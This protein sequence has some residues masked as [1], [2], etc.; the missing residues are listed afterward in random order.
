MNPLSDLLQ[1]LNSYKVLDA[2]C[3]DGVHAV[4]LKQNG[5]LDDFKQYYG[6]DISEKVIEIAKG[7]LTTNGVRFQTG[8]V[9][10]I[11]FEN[12]FFDASFSFGV[13]AY[14][15]NPLLSLQELTRVTKKGGMVGIWVYPRR[16]GLGGFVFSTVRK[17]CS[18]LGRRF[19]SGL[20]HTIV[21]FL[22]FLPTRSVASLRNASWNQCHEVVMVNIAPQN[23]IFPTKREVEGWFQKC[24]LQI[25]SED[26]SNSITIWGIK[27]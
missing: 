10:A 12:N 21:P 1:G 9:T 3:G 26:V 16:D 2:G 17:L 22:G 20:A 11:K 6:I 19:T 4:V 5:G 14:T 24:G 23:L 25:V 7:R 15:G 18:I 27:K 8:D 13:I